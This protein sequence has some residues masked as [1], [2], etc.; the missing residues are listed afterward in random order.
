MAKKK[1]KQGNKTG[2]PI[3][4]EEKVFLANLKK[5][6]FK[7]KNTLGS[8]LMPTVHKVAQVDELINKLEMHLIIQD[9]INCKY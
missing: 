6:G 8:I 7:E 2:N 4:K 5:M 3:S 1:K 9:R